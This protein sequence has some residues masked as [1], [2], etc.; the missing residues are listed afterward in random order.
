MYK[1]WNKINFV[2]IGTQLVYFTL[3][4]STLN[5]AIS[6]LKIIISIIMLW[7]YFNMPGMVPSQIKIK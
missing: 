1:Y 3:F 7:Y 2:L 6:K 4:L 5:V